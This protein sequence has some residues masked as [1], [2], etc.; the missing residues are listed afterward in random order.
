MDGLPSPIQIE[1]AISRIFLAE[2][3]HGS[4]IKYY[5]DYI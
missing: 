2:L 3:N 1:W 4:I 5:N